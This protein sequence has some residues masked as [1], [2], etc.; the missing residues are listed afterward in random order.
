M[1]KT[2]VYLT[3]AEAEALK[4]AAAATGRSQADLIREGISQVV[5]QA[6]VKKR[7][8]HSMGIA[9]GDG[10]PYEPWDPDELYKRIMGQE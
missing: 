9:N 1:R 8:F 10:T 2:S 6:G 3:D 4:Q 5:Q 7:H